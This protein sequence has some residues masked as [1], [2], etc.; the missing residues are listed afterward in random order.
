MFENWKFDRIADNIE[1][2]FQTAAPTPQILR[3]FFRQG[4]RHGKKG[5]PLSH[6]RDFIVNVV[7]LASDRIA[8]RHLDELHRIQR[9]LESLRKKN[10][11]RQGDLL[12]FTHEGQ[13]DNPNLITTQSANQMI[14]SGGPDMVAALD[15][16][17][18]SRR[19][20]EHSARQAQ[21]D[22]EIKRIQADLEEIAVAFTVAEKH[23]EQLPD[24][25]KQKVN[26]C[27]E[28]GEV[29]WTRYR[30][31]F[32][33]GSARRGPTEAPTDSPFVDIAFKKPLAM[34]VS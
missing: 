16:L 24:E 6:M 5:V 26:A 31:G 14:D 23:L 7:E 28:T 19:L 2:Q 4:V 34:E 18:N 30:L 11:L 29:L 1:S 12:K 21:R 27:H 32:L 10:E 17:K 25:L 9:D 15:R 3:R 13:M 33:R 8:V 22:S 20:Q